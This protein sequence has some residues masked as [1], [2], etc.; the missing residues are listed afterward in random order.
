MKKL[1]LCAALMGAIGLTSEARAD[2][3]KI[4][5]LSCNEAGGWGLI[6]G[7]SHA[8]RCT[9]AGNGRVEHYDGS[10]SKYGV[11][12]GYQ[13]SGVL[14]WT[15]FAPTNDPGPGALAGHYGGL[16]AGAT[17]GVGLAANALVGGSNNTIALQPL[18]IE[19]T[20]G[21]NVAAGVGDLSLHFHPRD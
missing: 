16:T 8:I 5:T 3:V 9:Y 12:I 11:D 14:V 7:A 17:V 10:I 13:Q 4:G 2:S 15:V 20:T 6:F 18:S 21:L 1:L 19:G